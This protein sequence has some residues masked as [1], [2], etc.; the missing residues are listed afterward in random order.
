MKLETFNL[1]RLNE[2]ITINEKSIHSELILNLLVLADRYISTLKTQDDKPTLEDLPLGVKQQVNIPLL[3]HISN[4]DYTQEA[5][6]IIS[7]IASDIETKLSRVSYQKQD[8][9]LQQLEVLQQEIKRILQWKKQSY[10]PQ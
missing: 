7:D 2:I 1:D 9:V 8:E 5:Q 6:Q 3:T 10:Y 4:V